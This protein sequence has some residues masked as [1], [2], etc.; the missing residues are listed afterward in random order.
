M[1]KILL[2]KHRKPK[3][4]KKLDHSTA[5]G[6]L[7]E[8]LMP[9]SA[10][11][12]IAASAIYSHHGIQDFYNPEH[13]KFLADLRREKSSSLPVDECIENLISDIGEDELNKY[14]KKAAS[15]SDFI[16]NQAM[17]DCVGT[18]AKYSNK[19]FIVG[20][21]QRMLISFLIDADRR[22]TE[23][24]MNNGEKFSV[25]PASEELWNE[26]LNNIE[27]KI[28]SLSDS[29]P[30]NSLRRTISE[31]CRQAAEEYN[32][33][34]IL[35]VPT[36]AGK[37]LSSLRFA[38]ANAKKFNKRRIIYAAPYQ[39]ITEQN[40]DEI[41]EAL[42]RSDIVLEHHS[43]LII[44]NEAE[45]QRYDRLTEDWSSLVVVTTSVQFLNTLFSGR[46]GCVRRFQSLCNSKR[47]EKRRQKDLHKH[48][49]GRGGSK[50]LV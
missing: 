25:E 12:E 31:I 33:R 20:M 37:T 18:N 44:E 38:V 17:A 23:D 29:K 14:A 3:R 28:E 47:I 4:F 15:E 13:E 21:Y 41:R 27:K 35:N 1:G 40:A 5:G 19:D 43:N 9:D 42:G 34:Y 45:Q 8:K 49:G 30:I 50:S 26:C 7:A 11:A 16:L 46:S 39:S 2:K 10:A 36:G 24:Y 48:A 6:I 22:N 32:P